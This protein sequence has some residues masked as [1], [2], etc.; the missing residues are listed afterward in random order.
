MAIAV[1]GASGQLGHLIILKL[2]ERGAEPASIVGLARTVDKAADLASLGVEI[3]HA[4]YSDPS[5]LPSALAGIDRLVLVSGS[6]IGQRAAQHRNVIEAAKAAG[7]SFI[8]YTSLLKANL[9]TL[10][11]AEEHRVTESDLATAGIAYVVLRNGWYT[12]NYTGNLAQ[13]IEAGAL[14]GAADDGR[15][16]SATRADY[17]EAA[18]VVALSSDFVSGA[19]LELGGDEPY[20]FETLAREIGQASGAPIE[21]R[22]LSHSGLR[23]QRL[24]N[25]VPEMWAD[26]A[27]ATDRGI[28]GG[29]LDTDSQELSKLIGRPT[30]PLA[31]AIASAL[32]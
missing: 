22:N 3:R 1:T 17:A 8:A 2:I 23:E 30:T 13:V 5:T 27:A 31:V 11:L 24:A 28:A 6:E 21:Y 26:F 29:D 4:D 20:T 19:V 14:Y 9:S 18:A 10:G 25:G 16:A 32:A 15:V 7:V 12:E